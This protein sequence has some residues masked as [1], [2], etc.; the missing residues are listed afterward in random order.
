MVV[1][2]SDVA[3]N[4]SKNL[5]VSINRLGNTATLIA[6]FESV[7][8][9]LPPIIT[10]PVG[11]AENDEAMAVIAILQLMVFC[12]RQLTMGCL[13]LMRAQQ[14]DALLHLR[15]AIESCGFAV[16]MSK[17]HELVRVWLNGVAGDQGYR[18]F[19]KAFGSR[20]IFPKAKHTDHDVVLDELYERYD[21]CSKKAHANVYGM[22]G[23]FEYG[24]SPEKFSFSL[25]VFDLPSDHSLVS[26]IYLIFD[27]H[28]RM[29]SLFG[30]MLEHYAG[31]RIKTWQVRHNWVERK[32]DV[33]REHWKTFV[34]DHR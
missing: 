16:R 25:S 30:R 8:D 29:L 17:H 20:D 4:E 11:G 32:L 28:K 31:D 6:D 14:G 2:I 9:G 23:H 26:S 15:R 22:S 21:L 3:E 34:P 19:K 7:Y 5:Q 18:E 33:H 12:R 24:D 27:A 13:T 1:S 10:L